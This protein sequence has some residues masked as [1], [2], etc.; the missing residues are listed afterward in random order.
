MIVRWTVRQRTYIYISIFSC[1]CS[2]L[3]SIFKC[4]MFSYVLK[5]VR[6]N[7]SNRPFCSS[8]L[9]YCRTKEETE[10]DQQRQRPKSSLAKP[11]KSCLV[12]RRPRSSA[13]M[14]ADDFLPESPNPPQYQS[15]SCSFDG[16]VDL[17]SSVQV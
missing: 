9:L 12:D 7:L 6:L 11:R 8:L 15:D 1:K 5:L 17:T 4:F 16:S 3:S 14:F 10:T 13:D 2:I